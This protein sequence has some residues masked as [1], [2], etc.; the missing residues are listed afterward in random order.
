MP[1]LCGTKDLKIHK[2]GV[3]KS[4]CRSDVEARKATVIGDELK[5]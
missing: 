3:M 4:C 5:I 1:S 2:S